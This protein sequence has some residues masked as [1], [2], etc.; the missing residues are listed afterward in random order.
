MMQ[1][2]VRNYA[3]VFSLLWMACSGI[4]TQCPYGE[5][6]SKPILDCP[7]FRMV[8]TKDNAV[9]YLNHDDSYPF[10]D[11]DPDSLGAIWQIYVNE[12]GVEHNPYY[13]GTPW[14][15]SWGNNRYLQVYE[16]HRLRI[17][18]STSDAHIGSY[19]DA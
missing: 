17:L 9:C 8:V 12:E 2:A 7:K 3:L 10:W 4:Y 14:D 19:H 16:E 18:N 11:C 1:F 13:L 6:R 5:S 15:D